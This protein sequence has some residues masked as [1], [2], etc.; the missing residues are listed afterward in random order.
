M[1]E[2]L[3]SSSMITEKCKDLHHYAQH[4]YAALCNNVFQKIDVTSILRDEEWSISWR[5]AGRVVSTIINGVGSDKIDYMDYYL[6]GM[7]VHSDF[8]DDYGVGNPYYGT[9]VPEGT[10]TEEVKKDIQSIGWRILTE[11]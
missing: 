8:T 9:R 10:I 11:Q 2:E 4:L 7:V 6:S 1:E 3:Y 5:G